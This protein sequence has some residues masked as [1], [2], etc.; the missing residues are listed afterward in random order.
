MRFSQIL[1]ESFE[2]RVMGT[3]HIDCCCFVHKSWTRAHVFY[4]QIN[5]HIKKP[6]ADSQRFSPCDAVA[7]RGESYRIVCR[8]KS[9]SNRRRFRQSR[10]VLPVLMLLMLHDSISVGRIVID[11]SWPLERTGPRRAIRRRTQRRRNYFRDAMSTTS[12]SSL[13]TRIGHKETNCETTRE[14]RPVHRCK[15]TFK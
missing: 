15:K 4:R 9:V 6:G 5:D 12:P 7:E 11:V 8:Q 3:I 13:P 10:Q 1:W 2:V 14:W